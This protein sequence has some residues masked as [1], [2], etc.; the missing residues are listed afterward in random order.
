MTDP[1][2]HVSTGCRQFGRRASSMST[3]A[4]SD[5]TSSTFAWAVRNSALTSRSGITPEAVTLTR[6]R[7]YAGPTMA[8]GRR[9]SQILA[10]V[11]TTSVGVAAPACV[12]MSFSDSMPRT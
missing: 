2:S 7:L 10:S 1:V 3:T 6:T 5:P 11:L 9:C 12:T 8:T 4:A